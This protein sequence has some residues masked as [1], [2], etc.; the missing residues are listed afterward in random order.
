[1]SEYLTIE[2]FW[3]RLVEKE[4][5]T[6]GGNFGMPV[7][8]PEQKGMPLQRRYAAGMI[9]YYLRK[10]RN[11]P[12]A[13]DISAAAKLPD[14]YDCRVCAASVM[15]VYAKGI[16]GALSA[17]PEKMSSS[18]FGLEEVLTGEE[19]EECLQRVWNPSLRTP[20]ETT[21]IDRHCS[22]SVSEEKALEAFQKDSNAIFIDV[23][24]ESEYA[25]KTVPGAKNVPLGRLLQNPFLAG[26]DREASYYLFCEGGFQSETAAA[27]M[28]SAGY[29][30]VFSFSLT[31]KFFFKNNREYFC[32]DGENP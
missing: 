15:Q 28:N 9:D 19:A 21:N 22:F 13:E 26:S 10:M 6:P 8:L 17:S 3:D 31:K 18:Y 24:T 30:N 20:P 7:F 27:C 4:V 32:D 1:M 29:R 16:I 11:E 25:R 12:P 23:R 2:E 14:I 5:T